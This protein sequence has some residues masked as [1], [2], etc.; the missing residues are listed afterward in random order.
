MSVHNS[1]GLRAIFSFLF[2]ILI[3]MWLFFYYNPQMKDIG[4]G[5]A[6]YQEKVWEGGKVNKKVK[7]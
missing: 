5:E 2:G 7:R 3:V 6:T 1:L 4:N